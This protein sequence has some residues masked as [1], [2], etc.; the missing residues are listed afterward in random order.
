MSMIWRLVRTTLILF[1]VIP[2]LTA[3][4]ATCLSGSC[5]QAITASK[6]LHGP[7][8][9]E[10]MGNK[11]CLSCHVPAGR[12]CE[13]GRPGSFRPLAP[14]AQ[15]CQRCHARGTGTQHSAKKID[16]LKCHDPHGSD[17]GFELRR[18]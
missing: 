6:F 11:G 5:H 18:Q 17:V 14:S 2:A 4:A 15:M 7:V 10:Q 13:P 16:C 8:A 3:G 12:D 9:A 1:A